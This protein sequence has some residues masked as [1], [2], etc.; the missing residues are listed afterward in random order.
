MRRLAI[1]QVVL[2]LS[3][4]L[5]L[6]G[7]AH[8][9]GTAEKCAEVEAGVSELKADFAA[10][11]DDANSLGDRPE[12]TILNDSKWW[13]DGTRDDSAGLAWDQEADAIRNRNRH[14]LVAAGNLV[15]Q[16]PECF[17]PVEVAKVQ[18]GLDGLN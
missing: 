12:S 8:D 7:C 11:A 18:A 13:Y 2:V 14:L 5:A 1:G 9:G 10:V 15:V 3:S 16:N 17:D 6:A 4:W